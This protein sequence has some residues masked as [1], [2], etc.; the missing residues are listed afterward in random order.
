LGASVISYCTPPLLA[1]GSTWR[2][3]TP[4]RWREVARDALPLKAA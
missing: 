1:L 4:R 3:Y 2:L